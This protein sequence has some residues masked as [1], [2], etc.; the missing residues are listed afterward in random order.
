MSNSEEYLDDLLKSLS[1]EKD[2]ENTDNDG[3]SIKEKVMD[4]KQ[5][6]GLLDEAQLK[7]EGLSEEDDF[8]KEFEKEM[9]ADNLTDFLK[10]FEAELNQDQEL[11]QSNQAD[12]KS[13]KEEKPLNE[14]SEEDIISD[15][16]T[17]A[18]PLPTEDENFSGDML[19]EIEEAEKMPDTIAEEN[20]EE[21]NETDNG[22]ESIDIEEVSDLN[23]DQS[24][25]SIEDEPINSDMQEDPEVSQ[26]VLTQETIAESPAEDIESLLPTEDM[27]VQ[28]EYS[29]EISN[30]KNELEENNDLDNTMQDLLG[31]DMFDLSTDEE[32]NKS[33]EANIVEEKI[34]LSDEDELLSLLSDLGDDGDLADIGMMLQAD[35]NNE[36]IEAGALNKESDA[37]DLSKYADA[38]EALDGSPMPEAEETKKKSKKSID[39]NENEIEQ[40][41]G[42]FKK[43]SG[44]LFGPDIEEDEEAE[45]AELEAEE[46]KKAELNQAK[47]EAKEAKKKEQ[48]EKK[49]EKQK[50]DQEKKELQEA[51]ANEKKEKRLAELALEPPDT[52]P[53]IPKKLI[54]LVAVLAVS[55]F[56]L[57]SLTV[58]LVGYK[59]MINQATDYYNAKDYLSAYA[60]LAGATLKTSD[61]KLYNQTKLLANVQQE[62]KAYESLISKNK[63]ELALDSLIKGVGRYNTGS[64]DAGT[65]GITDEYNQI[66]SQITQ[67]LSAKFGLSADEAEQIYNLDTRGKYTIQVKDVISKAGLK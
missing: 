57:Q 44:L 39:K 35:A 5:S 16:S 22:L 56:A 30:Q 1:D 13:R 31:E 27:D 25:D 19:T 33:E 32:E 50:A 59:L 64:K 6:F 52:T 8:L 60:K 45:K 2:S 37:Q 42:F 20:I 43:L 9:N 41:Q 7:Q 55:I 21:L 53:K 66:E 61:Q 62:Y 58:N 34:P 67:E 47:T 26:E 49:A 14:E 23:I 12:A 15:I 11:D 10:D 29:E 3:M 63:Y 4:E 17:S 24:A 38:L 54:G 28:K 48:S 46:A 18:E 65:Y 40:N 51:Q 36:P